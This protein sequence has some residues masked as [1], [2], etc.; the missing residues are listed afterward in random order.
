M[1]KCESCKVPIGIQDD[2]DLRFCE[3]CVCLEEHEISFKDAH[4]N[5]LEARYKKSKLLIIK[6]ASIEDLKQ[7]EHVQ[8]L[9]DELNYYAESTNWYTT[10]S[11]DLCI[12][13]C[14]IANDGESF[15]DLD[16]QGNNK[17]LLLSG[18]RARTKLKEWE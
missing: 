4:L 1:S 18:R 15:G 2:D 10:A 17:V 5:E 14:S 13:N 3:E 8:G 6:D 12:R 9:L 11:D 16:E 7:N